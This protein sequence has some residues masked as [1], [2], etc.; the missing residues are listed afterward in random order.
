MKEKEMREVLSEEEEEEEEEEKEAK[1][2][3]TK[4]KKK[5]KKKKK[6]AHKQAP[7]PALFPEDCPITEAEMR[8]AAA[9]LRKLWGGNRN[10]SH[11]DLPAFRPLRK[12]VGPFARKMSK[13]MFGGKGRS[14]YEEKKIIAQE[15]RARVAQRKAFDRAQINKSAMRQRRLEKLADLTKRQ[16]PTLPMVPDGFVGETPAAPGV[17]SGVLADAARARTAEATG[18]GGKDGATGDAAA[19]AAV[20]VAATA[21]DGT[22]D[23]GAGTVG[24]MYR[25]I[26]NP[27]ACYICKARFNRLHPFYDQLCPSCA[28][29]NYAKR[30]Q[31]CQ[32]NG[33]V[34]LVTGGRVKIGFCVAVKL[35][36]WGAAVIVTSRFPCDCARRYAREPD[37][38]EWKDRLHIYGIDFRDMRRV[39]MFCDHLLATQDRLDVLINNACQTIRRPA[40]YY[41]PLLEHEA[42]TIDAIEDF[43]LS[44]SRSSSSGDGNDCGGGSGG[45]SGG[46]SKRARGTSTAEGLRTVLA[47]NFAL[48]ESTHRAQQRFLE[49]G[50]PSHVEKTSP[51][52]STIATSAAQS[53]M[54]LLPEDVLSAAEL[55]LPKDAI[56]AN[57]QQLDLRKRN[58]WIMKMEE[59]QTPELAE[60]FAINAIAPFVLNSRLAPLMRR[61]DGAGGEGGADARFIVNVS[62]MEGKFY[63]VKSAYHPHTNMAK[64]ALNMMTR[65]SAE[66]LAKPGSRIFMTAVDTG[67]INDENPVEKAAKYAKTHNFQTPLDEVDAAARILDPVAVGVNEGKLLFGVFLKDY[68]ETEW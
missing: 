67:W 48:L 26:E 24:A 61:C 49:E 36:R 13:E 60:V 21:P 23:G 5:K 62:A 3:I 35:L 47:N 10:F 12:A 46:S 68:F 32:L 6:T 52:G 2:K 7:V 56:D 43:V 25:R 16:D 63:R 19:H 53:Q 22:N 51:Q 11:F 38:D 1:K 33:R 66:D 4:K 15:K 64:A 41:H 39:E 31:M 50:G 8:A 17:G 30:K 34:A 57:G 40:A 45:G 9:T 37:F 59:I 44:T 29:L 55:P 42:D 54:V 65:T 28:T 58:T 18:S 27:R 14:E 20:T